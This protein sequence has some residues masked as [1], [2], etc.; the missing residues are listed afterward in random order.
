MDVTGIVDGDQLRAQQAALPGPGP[1]RL[2]G[3][4]RG[5]PRRVEDVAGGAQVTLAVTF[6]IEGGTKPVCVAEVLFRYYS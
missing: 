2:E 4:G 1:G 5:H 3:A 6:E